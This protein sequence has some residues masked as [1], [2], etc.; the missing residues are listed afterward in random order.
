MNEIANRLVNHLL[1][2][3]CTSSENAE[4]IE[5]EGFR[6]GKKPGMPRNQTFL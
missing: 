2:W 4:A 6:P 5:R 3:H 1:L